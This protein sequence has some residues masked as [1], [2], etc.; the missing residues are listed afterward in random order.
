MTGEDAE[1]RSLQRID[2]RGELPWIEQISEVEEKPSP[3]LVA[4]VRDAFEVEEGGFDAHE[5]SEEGNPT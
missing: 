3:V 4:V 5:L 2:A 1:G